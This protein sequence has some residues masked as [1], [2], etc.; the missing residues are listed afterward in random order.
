MKKKRRTDLPSL[1]SD[2]NRIRRQI[3]AFKA[4]SSL[5]Q[6]G[7]LK[8]HEKI[9]ISSKECLVEE[10]GLTLELREED[11]T[12]RNKEQ[13]YRSH[14]SAELD[15]S[16]HQKRRI[17]LPKINKK[18]SSSAIESSFREKE[19]DSLLPQLQGTAILR[20]SRTFAVADC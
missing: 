15:K 6:A 16:L 17:A 5:S 7:N 4:S 12:A 19:V 1:Q 20:R 3:E 13:R 2:L 11:L 10:T 9:A 14:S 8:V 18:K